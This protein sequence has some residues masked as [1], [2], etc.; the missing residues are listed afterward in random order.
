MKAKRGQA[1]INYVRQLNLKIRRDL[2]KGHPRWALAPIYAAEFILALSVLSAG[3]RFILNPIC[4]WIDNFSF[5]TQKAADIRSIKEEVPASAPT[6]LAASKPAPSVSA[7]RPVQQKALLTN[8]S[9][10][11]SAVPSETTAV[12]DTEAA[13]TPTKELRDI[14]T[15][16]TP[17]KVNTESV[18]PPVAQ[19]PA[20][21]APVVRSPASVAPAAQ[22]INDKF[23]IWGA[24]FDDETKVSQ[25]KDYLVSK[26]IKAAKT[27]QPGELA[28]NSYYFHVQV[29][30][31]EYMDL[32]KFVQT[33]KFKDFW[34]EEVQSNGRERSKHRR[35]VFQ[36]KL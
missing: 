18:S 16:Q 21:E 22:V 30:E 23:Y 12:T 4:E 34:F 8:E 27:I 2:P 5:S 26:N 14:T 20:V 19:T 6:M 36:V 7:A 35:V 24:K 17:E 1:V 25:L 31:N 9:K 32:L 13:Y 15:E 33:L 3:N 10:T 29:P 11:E 28:E